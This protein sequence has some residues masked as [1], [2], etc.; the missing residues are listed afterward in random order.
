MFLITANRAQSV[1]SVRR[2]SHGGGPEEGHTALG[3]T[4][5][6]MLVSKDVE[7]R[8]GFEHPEARR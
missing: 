6:G 8:V 1:Q 3:E 2:K 5:K 4:R 7:K